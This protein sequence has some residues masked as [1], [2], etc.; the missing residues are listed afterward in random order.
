M[1]QKGILKSKFI[2]DLKEVE[3]LVQRSWFIKM[4]VCQ[5]TSNFFTLA[6]MSYIFLND[7]QQFKQVQGKK[8]HTT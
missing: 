7:W 3:I 8:N 5:A 1:F 2:E 4:V 6:V